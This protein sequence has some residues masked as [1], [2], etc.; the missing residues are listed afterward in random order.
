VLLRFDGVLHASDLPVQSFARHLTQTLPADQVRV[1]IA[2]M[3]GFLEG[4]PELI[5]EGIELAGAE[6]GYQ[7]VEILGRAAGLSAETITAAYR[8]SRVDL[9]GSAWAVDASDGLEDLIAAIKGQAHLAV[10]T[11]PG[12][13]APAAVLD[14]AGIGLEVV[15]APIT[16]THAPQLIENAS[17]TRVLVV[18]TRW[19]VN[20][21]TLATWAS[22]PRLSIDTGWAGARR[23]C[24]RPTW[25]DCSSRSS[26]GARSPPPKRGNAMMNNRHDEHQ[27]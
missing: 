12:D 23:P 18:G 20:S 6:D 2:G 19:A 26:V 21:R 10:L 15:D 7:A 9:A 11:E 14:S 5:P 13:P 24:A 16:R 22:P 25:R 27:T 8:A 1:L 4:K 3:R 17:P